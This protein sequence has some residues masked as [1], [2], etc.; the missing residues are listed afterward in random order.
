MRRR[1]Q[2][3]IMGGFGHPHEEPRLR[4]RRMSSGWAAVLLCACASATAAE[5]QS[6]EDAWWT[7][8]MLAASAASLPQGHFLLEPYLFDVISY[9]AHRR[10]RIAPRR[11][12][13]S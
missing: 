3:L 4:Q 9:R 13:R 6:R 5:R 7:G 10:Q 8:P 11:V 2:P 12:G 1:G